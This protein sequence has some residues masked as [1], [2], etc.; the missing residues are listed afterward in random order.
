MKKL[1]QDSNEIINSTDVPI[2]KSLL[3]LCFKMT[4]NI[5]KIIDEANHS[6]IKSD[7]TISVFIFRRL[8]FHKV[9]LIF[10]SN[11]SLKLGIF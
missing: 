11:Q 4:S 8:I 6:I 1:D 10:Q 3:L 5:K 2:K 9:K 7:K